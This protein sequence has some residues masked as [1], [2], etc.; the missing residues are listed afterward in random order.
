VSDFAPILALLEP[1]SRRFSEAGHELYL[2][3]GIVRDRVAASMEGE[4][5]AVVD[6]LVSSDVDLTT[7]AR[8]EVTKALIADLASAVWTQ[9]ERFGTIGATVNGLTLEVTT[10]RAESY[11]D[12]SR[13]PEVVFG[14][15]L[16]TDL[17]RRDFTL[18]AMAVSTSDGVL[19]DPFGGEDDLRARHLRTPLDPEISF[20][21]D[22]L[23]ILRAARF[24]PRF[25][26]EVG[27]DL[28]NAATDLGHRLS[29]VSIERIREEWERLLAVAEPRSGLEFLESHGLL[30]FISP[31]VDVH[32][33]RNEALLRAGSAAS[34]LVRRAGF[35]FDLG[36]AGA[37][38]RLLVLRYSRADIAMTITVL[39]TAGQVATCDRSPEA[40]RR[41]VAEAGQHGEPLLVDESIVLAGHTGELVQA[42][43]FKEALGLLR[44]H[45][46][47]TNF[48][49]PVNGDEV[50][51]VLGLAPGRSVGSALSWLREQRLARGPLG[52]DE[53]LG[54]LAEYP[55]LD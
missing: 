26:L 17:S 15:D 48:D 28:S 44:L 23:R 42:E 33:L 36:V 49:P 25:D 16:Y 4:F 40:V 22:P 1:V 30:R 21:D 18:N 50:M 27:T 32:R 5:P 8:P 54:L 34:P 14:K 39:K 24:L 37:R 38:N 19:H 11:S 13:K 35:F 10:F 55:G 3:G 52:H 47:L 31:E 29:I 7:D 20:S 51:K 2:V 9:G 45:E 43:R 46:D 41:L 12:H 53:A 6:D